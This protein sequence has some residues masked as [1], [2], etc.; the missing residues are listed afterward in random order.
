MAL[1]RVLSPQSESEIVVVTSLLEAHDI[2]VF[3][4]GRHLGSLLPGLQIGNYNTQ[5]IMV[6]EERAADALELLSDFRQIDAGTTPAPLPWRDRLR[7]V[8]EGF[9]FGWL[10]PGRRNDK[11]TDPRDEDA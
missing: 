8:L 5:S 6:P 1:V 11:K 3:I 9:L 10:V 7:V 2:P 4:H